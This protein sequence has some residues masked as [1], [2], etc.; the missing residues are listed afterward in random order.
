[1]TVNL[2]PLAFPA[3]CWCIAALACCGLWDEP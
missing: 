2:T 3:L 1:M